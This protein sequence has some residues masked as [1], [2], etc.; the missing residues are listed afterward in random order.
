[1]STQCGTNAAS[2]ETKRALK[3]AAHSFYQQ[4]VHVLRLR[5]QLEKAHPGIQYSLFHI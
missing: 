1:M 3:S 4:V 2:M 5:V